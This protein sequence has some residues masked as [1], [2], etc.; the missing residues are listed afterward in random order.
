MNA[1][2]CAGQRVA[3][4]ARTMASAARRCSASSP[5][6]AP[7]RS[8]ATAATVLADGRGAVEQV[9]GA[10]DQRLGVVAGGEQPARRRRPRTA[11]SRASAVAAASADPAGLRR[12]PRPGG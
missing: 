3:E 7:S 10:H 2:G 5:V 6:R 8:R 12:W 1:G 4:Q 11:S 9:L